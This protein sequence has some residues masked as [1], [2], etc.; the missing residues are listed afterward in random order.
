[1][2]D[3]TAEQ[4]L[5]R[6]A[7]V[8]A[9][10]DAGGQAS[11][12]AVGQALLDRGNALR[13]LGRPD[14]AYAS[15]AECLQ[16]FDDGKA[17]ADDWAL[18]CLI[19]A[20]ETARLSGQLSDATRYLDD[21]MRREGQPRSWGPWLRAEVMWNRAL[22]A[23][24]TDRIE[25]ALAEL[26]RLCAFV[27]PALFEEIPREW[28]AWS[29]ITQARMLLTDG[30]TAKAA[31]VWEEMWARF[32][33]A[34]PAAQID[35]VCEAALKLGVRAQ[36]SERYQDAIEF[37]SFVIEHQHAINERAQ[38][39]VDDALYQRARAFGSLDREL[40]A[41]DDAERL[42]SRMVDDDDDRQLTTLI[43]A[44]ALKAAL[45]VRLDPHDE[46]KLV[47]L[48]R[49]VR[50]LLNRPLGSERRDALIVALTYGCS[51]GLIETGQWQEALDCY[52]LV[53]DSQAQIGGIRVALIR[54]VD[55]ATALIELNRSEHA[56]RQLKAAIATPQPNEAEAPV[57]EYARQQLDQLADEL[58]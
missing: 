53:G 54:Q 44:W 9:A 31:A 48:T 18:R 34:P 56:V 15:F 49:E 51:S 39:R 55:S 2:T 26:R 37:L 46:D 32:A 4:Q 19:D 45:L 35:A 42:I 33:I 6:A 40:E 8:L 1:M 22:I 41:I 5:A 21:A 11:D 29:L 12:D 17:V 36:E 52:E 3:T 58:A 20:A 23:K 10:A 16:R 30:Q 43:N 27:E 24:A 47:S 38:W 25:D 50:R 13:A 28:M 7:A 57:I 14:E